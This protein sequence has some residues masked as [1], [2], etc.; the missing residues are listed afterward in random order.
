[1][2]LIKGVLFVLVGL[3][4]MVTLISLLIPSRV[5]VTRA[6][7]VTGDSLKIFD[8]VS[9]LKKWKDWQPVFQADSANIRYSTV[10]DNINSSAEWETNG[11]KNRVVI[12]EKKYP[13]VKLALQREGENEVENIISLMP[14]QEQGNM[15]VQW[16]SVTKLKWYPWEKFG[17]I[18]LEKITGPGYE[19]ALKSLKDYLETHH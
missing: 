16:T 5:V 14:V 10:T 3:F 15:Q 9:D 19:A 6:V 8:E 12:T 2:K 18:F 4:I 17:G 7:P 13:V 1:M 11:K